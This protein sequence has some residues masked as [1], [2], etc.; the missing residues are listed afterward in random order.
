MHA[1]LNSNS[2]VHGAAFEINE[3]RPDSALPDSPRSVVSARDYADSQV[4][5]S[6][7]LPKKPF[8]RHPPQ[9]IKELTMSITTK[10]KRIGMVVAA[11]AMGAAGFGLSAALA[12]AAQAI[13]AAQRSCAFTV[14]NNVP[15]N[16]WQPVTGSAVTIN[17]GGAARNVVVNFNA[18]A[19]VTANAEI[20]IG[21]RIDA[22]AVQT[23]G[24]QN[25]ANH[26][27]YWQTRHSMVVMNVPSGSHTIRP[28][29][30]ISGGAGTSGVI[31][32][33]C[34]TAEAYTS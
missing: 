34:L 20:R 17:N 1:T 8:R 30:R 10:V 2:A 4:N 26:T 11:T 28:Y 31:H 21:Y 12:P 13:P 33:R 14:L 32:S 24:A 6:F 29:W 16:G 22:G 9:S 18:D 19:G 27:Q 25:F 7:V 23:P 5:C 15:A 3:F